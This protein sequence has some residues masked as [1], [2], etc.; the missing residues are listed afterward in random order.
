MVKINDKSQLKKYSNQIETLNK[1]IQET[2]CRRNVELFFSFD[3]VNSST[4][5]TLNFIS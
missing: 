1:E 5:K 2:L 4:Y 3:I